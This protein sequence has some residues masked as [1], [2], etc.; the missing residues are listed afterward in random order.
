M[1]NRFGLL[2]MIMVLSLGAGA[3]SV[4]PVLYNSWQAGNA[5]FECGQVECCNAVFHYKFDDWGDETY[6]GSYDIDSDEDGIVENV[7]IISN[8]DG[9]S[10]DWTSDGLVYCVIVKGSNAANVYCYEGGSTSDT[11][12]FAPTSTNRKGKIIQHAISHGTFCYNNPPECKWVEETA[13]ADGD[14]YVTKGN[15]A[16]YVA[17]NGVEKTVDLIAGQ[18]MVAGEVSFSKADNGNVTI[19]IT[20]KDGWRFKDVEENVSIQDYE[21]APSGN[22]SPGQFAWKDYA[23]DSPFSIEVPANNYYGVHVDVEWED[24]PE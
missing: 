3:A 13:W 11:G 6:D 16:M 14:R 15:W 19:T 10:F 20:L 7:I 2:C 9:Y 24:C 12:L 4:E 1:K 21:S 17:Y 23:T 22:P 18:N 8:N 5:A